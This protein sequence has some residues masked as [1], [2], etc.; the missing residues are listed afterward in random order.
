MLRAL[1]HEVHPTAIARSCLVIRVGK[2]EMG[3][4]SRMWRWNL[5]K[6]MRSV[7]LPIMPRSDDRTSSPHTP[8]TS[9]STP[10]APHSPWGRTRISPAGISSTVPELSR[11]ATTPVSRVIRPRSSPTA[12]T[13]DA[14]LR[15]HT[16]WPSVHT[17]LWAPALLLGGAVLPDH[18]VLAA[19]SLL[20]RT[21][22]A[23]E[24]GLREG[25]PQ[26][27]AVRSR[28]SGSRTP[29][30]APA[31]STSRPPVKPSKVQSEGG[32]RLPSERRPARRS[33]RTRPLPTD[34]DPPGSCTPSTR[35][36]P[37]RTGSS[38]D[39]GGPSP[40]EIALQG[41]SA[42]EVRRAG[43]VRVGAHLCGAPDR[44]C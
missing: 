25:V 26:R 7:S 38:H 11:S 13:S 2:D 44:R 22:N 31:A 39:G 17:A 12:W 14:T 35:S 8:S 36:G 16:R 42:F 21:R 32:R 6:N 33:F 10:T 9:G 3:P 40:L 34:F 20:T 30:P 4:K 24:P 1:G 5:I 37:T 15:S 28:G 19:G 18:S 29:R 41:G 27:C 43:P 23:P